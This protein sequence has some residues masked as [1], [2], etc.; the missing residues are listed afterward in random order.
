MKYV[1]NKQYM[2]NYFSTW[3]LSGAGFEVLDCLL[4]KHDFIQLRI[5][6]PHHPHSLGTISDIIHFRYLKIRKNVG[7]ETYGW[8]IKP[9]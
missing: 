7:R 4:V 3:I 5:E 9:N 1:K 6:M 8:R 2:A